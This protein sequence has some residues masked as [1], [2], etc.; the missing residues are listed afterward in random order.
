MQEFSLPF[1][2]IHTMVHFAGGRKA[3]IFGGEGYMLDDTGDGPSPCV[4]ILDVDTLVWTRNVTHTPEDE[5]NPGARSL[6]V[7]TVRLCQEGPGQ[8]P[9]FLLCLREEGQPAGGAALHQ[10]V[11]FLP[12]VCMHVSY[13]CCAICTSS[14][15]YPCLALRT[16]GIKR[17]S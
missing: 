13:R 9:P 1:I 10:P 7:T 11:L 14:R 16:A 2:S 6:H 8:W 12:Q 5:H 15:L 4:Y 17:G 3:I